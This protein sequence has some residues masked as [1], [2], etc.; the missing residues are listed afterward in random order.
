MI[1]KTKKTIVIELEENEAF[2]VREFIFQ[3]MPEHN[4][5]EAIEKE[6]LKLA[7]EIEAQGI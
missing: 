3:Y 2:S 1:V 7:N 4:K 5:R 6:S